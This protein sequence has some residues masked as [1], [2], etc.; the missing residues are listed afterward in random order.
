MSEHEPMTPTERHLFA[1]VRWLMT[2]VEVSEI[3]IPDEE[4][5]RWDDRAVVMFHNLTD[6][7]THL[8]L[9]DAGP[10]PDDPDSAT[11]GVM[12][13]PVRRS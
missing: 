2:R 10:N 11:V 4:L 6:C 9:V 12:F 1:V 13:E 7:T 8:Q 5:A 3:V